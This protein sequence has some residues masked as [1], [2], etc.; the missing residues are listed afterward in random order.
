LTTGWRRYTLKANFEGFLMISIARIMAGLSAPMLA[1]AFCL[2]GASAT[3][4][5]CQLQMVAQFPLVMEGNTALVDARINGRPARFLVDTGSGVTLIGRPA[6][7]A[8][9]LEAFA[10][11]MTMYGVGGSDRASQTTIREFKLGDATVHNFTMIVSG[12]GLKSSRYVG[13]IGEDFLSQT[14]VELD[15]AQ[16]VM[17]L[18]TP[19]DCAGDQV[20][21]WRKPYSEAAIA[22]SNSGGKLETYVSL[23]GQRALAEIDTGAYTSVVTTGVA[24]RV[25]IPLQG[26][27]VKPAG[28]S[29][30]IGKGFVQTSEA[31]FPIF[32]I[33]DETIKNAKLRVADLF[34]HDKEVKL[35]SHVSEQVVE[36]PSML[37]GADFIR[38]HRI[39]IAKS[40]G[41]LYFSYNGGPI[42]QVVRPQPD[43][44]QAAPAPAA[45]A[46]ARP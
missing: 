11:D 39:Y 2:S 25:G 30:G 7:A 32:A 28:V 5:A 3:F 15:F 8:L 12:P 26:E 22:P 19:K 10:T 35:G 20:V 4:A 38:A 14:D 16:G 6:A 46:P 40:Q 34:V 31:V 21:Y 1:T 23:N 37:L 9:G 36:M 18:I 17:R 42:F 24:E 27:G 45:S 29:G 41:K 44:P 13:I 33:G 43:E